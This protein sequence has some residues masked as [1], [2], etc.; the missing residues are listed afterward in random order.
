MMVACDGAERKPMATC[1]HTGDAVGEERLQ[2]ETPPLTRW[3][4]TTRFGLRPAEGGLALVQDFLNTAGRAPHLPDLLGN[5]TRARAWSRQAAET[6][7]LHRGVRAAAPALTAP[8][9]AELRR[10]RQIV[11]ALVSGE[12]LGDATTELGAGGLT[13]S[14][15]GEL[16]WQPMESGW[17]WWASAVCSE[18][19]LSQHSRTWRRLKRCGNRGCPAMFYDRSWNGSGVLHAYSCRGAIRSAD[20]S[21][22]G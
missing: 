14:R 17:R 16:H 5:P 3:L 18:V 11:G 12:V 10:L 2:R 6:W 21:L 20:R 22:L 15:N 8:D 13:L 1:F 4:A 7:S 9:V 19:L